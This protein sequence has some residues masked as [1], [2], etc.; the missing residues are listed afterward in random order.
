MS[1]TTNVFV[2]KSGRYCH[3]SVEKYVLF[4]TSEFIQCFLYNYE[5]CPVQI[6]TVICN[7][8]TACGRDS[9]TKETYIWASP[10]ENLSSG[11]VT[12]HT[13]LQRIARIMKFP[14]RQA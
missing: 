4:R 10:Q 3:F 12:R 1:T 2:K 8:R 5:I 11:L 7:C 13:Q 14:M 6:T 9:Y